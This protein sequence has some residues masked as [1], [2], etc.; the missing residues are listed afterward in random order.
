VTAAK[1]RQIASAVNLKASDLPDYKGKPHQETASDRANETKLAQCAGTTL[2]TQDIVDAYSPD[3]GKGNGL[4]QQEISSDV[5][6]VPTTSDVQH[7]LAAI[8]SSKAQQC[9]KTFLKKALSQQAGNQA[10]LVSVSLTPTQPSTGGSNPSFGYRVTVVLSAS[11]QQIPVYY[12]V[13]GVAA[14]TAEVQLTA[15]EIGQQ[16][17]TATLT[18]LESLLTNRANQAVGS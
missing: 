12:E 3:F 5:T 8:T 1:A 6:V 4:G 13:F 18:Q 9:L 16:F 17:P 11:G 10:K 7:D 14:G 15:Y 2:P